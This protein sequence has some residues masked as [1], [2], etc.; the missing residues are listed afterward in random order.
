MKLTEAQYELIE[1]YLGD[2][3]SA[4][5]KASFEEE[6]NTDDELR[7]EVNR[8]QAIRLGLRALGIE[9]ALEQ[10]RDQ[11][12]ATTPAT[13][14]KPEP[15]TIVRPLGNWR[16]WA[17]AASVLLILGIGY[18]AYQQTAS[19]Q[20]DLAYA[21]TLRS[22]TND[23]L[24]KSFP[25]GNVSSGTRAQ[26]LQA[27]ANYKAGKY[28]DVISQLRTLSTDKQTVHYKAYFLGLSYLANKQPTEAIPLLIQ[29]QS[30]PLVKLRQKADWFLALA[31][32]KNDQKEKAL[33]MLTRISNDK[34]NP[35]H[36]L[37]LRVLQKIR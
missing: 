36:P 22:D 27:L 4:S 13:A 8:Q 30:T 29:A 7:Q 9:R 6:I 23:E 25:S 24:L 33:P 12:K 15:Q 34:A 11:Y 3:L 1:A 28:E 21:E 16:Y 31:Y 5:D 17:V 10:A 26:F 19:R 2:E 37:A 35:F 20:I 18:L 32:V 14:T